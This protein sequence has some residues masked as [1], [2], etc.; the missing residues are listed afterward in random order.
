[1]KNEQTSYNLL[2]NDLPTKININGKIYDINYDYRTAL[3]IMMALEDTQLFN[4]EKVLIM[5]NLLYKEKIPEED[6][7]EACRKACLFIDCGKS[8]E[9]KKETKRIYSF[10]KDGNYIFTGINSTHQ[11]DI[12]K[13]TNL[14][15][16]KFM[17]LFMD[18]NTE[19]TFNELVYYRKRRNEGKLTKEEKEEYKKIKDLVELDEIPSEDIKAIKAAREEFL[20]RMKS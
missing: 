9:E 20:K 6:L 10:S 17:A 8:N 14:H 5:V 12:T 11:I 19:C 16:W 7:E 3:K 1:M 15:W 4:S 2:I 13:I 18:M